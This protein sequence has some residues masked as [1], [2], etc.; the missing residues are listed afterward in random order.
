M[1]VVAEILLSRELTNYYI[2]QIAKTI[3]RVTFALISPNIYTF[4]LLQL[5]FIGTH[6]QGKFALCSVWY[7]LDANFTWQTAFFLNR[8]Q[9]LKL[10]EASG[11]FAT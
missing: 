8:L 5:W 9:D 7:V 3:P 11:K 4:S 6:I 1:L 2:L 10:T